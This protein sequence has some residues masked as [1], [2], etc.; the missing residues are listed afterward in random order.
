MHEI[1][2]FMCNF[3]KHFKIVFFFN[4]QWDYRRVTKNVDI[5]LIVG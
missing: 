5:F 4:L 3:A 1:I 2:N